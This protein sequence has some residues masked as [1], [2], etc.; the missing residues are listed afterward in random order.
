MK[1][2]CADLSN[3]GKEWSLKLKTKE[4]SYNTLNGSFFSPFRAQIMP[5]IDTGI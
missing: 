1:A 4:A 3:T 5:Y 2:K